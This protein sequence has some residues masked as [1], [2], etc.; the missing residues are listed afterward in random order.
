[1]FLRLIENPPAFA[2]AA[3]RRQTDAGRPRAFHL[4]V[5]QAILR[6]ASRRIRSDFCHADE[7]VSRLEAYLDVRCDDEGR[8]ESRRRLPAGRQG[9]F[10]TA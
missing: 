1:M 3:S 7:L 10:S 4:P 6:V 8:G 9:R 5:R 2:E